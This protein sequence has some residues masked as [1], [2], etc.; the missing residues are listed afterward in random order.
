M[1]TTRFVHPVRRAARRPV[2]PARQAGL[3]LVEIMVSLTLGLVVLLAIGS[4]YI[5]SRQTYRVQE[6]NARL[7][8]AGKYALE[9][10]G[11]SIRQSGADSDMVFNPVTVT[12]ECVPP[13]CTPINGINGA[14][15]TADTLA[16]ELYAG[17][18][19]DAGGGVWVTRD[20]TG[21]QIAAGAV[22][23]NTFNVVGTDLRCTGSVGGTQTL[24]SDIED[25]QV[26]YGIDTTGDQSA[27]RYVDAPADWRQVVTARVCVLARSA[28]NGLVSGA[29]R[30]LNCAG[31]LGTAA[32]GSE[33]TDAAD[34]RLHRTF[35]A[36]YNLRNRVN[37]AP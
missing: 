30:Y 11:R 6:D 13:A 9:V 25:L 35:V 5:G 24:V 16:V 18:E 15:G 12:L 33:F 31:A 1:M 32:A 22:I 20:C 19:E 28:N 37:G 17:R 23:T 3:T 14:A 27:D 21:G 4:V 29:Q 36:T 8:E 26:I 10:I 34:Q 7:Q 2:Q